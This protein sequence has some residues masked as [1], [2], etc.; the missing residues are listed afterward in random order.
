VGARAAESCTNTL[1]RCACS[2]P[3]W[4]WTVLVTSLIPQ[5][6]LDF[7]L[8]NHERYLTR[9]RSLFRS[10]DTDGDGIVSVGSCVPWCLRVFHVERLG[11]RGFIAYSQMNFIGW[12]THWARILE[13][14]PWK[15]T[16]PRLTHI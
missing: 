5:V 7:Q 3:L 1:C 12:C 2:R 11:S 16:L 15:A 9:F 4:V 8:K 14:M 13:M 10:I 6:L